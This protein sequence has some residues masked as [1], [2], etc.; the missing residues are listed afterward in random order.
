MTFSVPNEFTELITSFHSLEMLDL[1]RITIRTRDVAR[2]IPFTFS[3]LLH[4][5]TLFLHTQ[6]PLTWFLSAVRFPPRQDLRFFRIQNE[7]MD[8]V[9]AILQSQGPSI[10]KLSLCCRGTFIATRCYSG[11]PS[12]LFFLLQLSPTAST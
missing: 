11:S 8:A 12:N 5:V 6:D 7:D 2:I 9:Q 3:P 10:V 4:T 1:C